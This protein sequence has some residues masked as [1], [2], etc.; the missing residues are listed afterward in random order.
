MN[1]AVTIAVLTHNRSRSLL[2]TVESLQTFT[3]YEP[4]KL[5]ILDSGS[6]TGHRNAIARLAQMPNVTLA[7]FPQPLTCCE[8]RRHIL[9][10]V[11]TPFVVYLDDDIT[12]TPRWL[13]RMMFWMQGQGDKCGAVAAQL[14]LDGLNP[15]SGARYIQNG[16]IQAH[17]FGYTGECD[18]C[19]GG[20]TL[21]RT[22]ALKKTEFR[23]EYSCGSEDMDMLLQLKR[24][25]GYSIQSCDVILHHVHEPQGKFDRQRWRDVDILDSSIGLWHRWGI[26]TK[27]IFQACR[28]VQHGVGIRSDQS[29]AVLQIMHAWIQEGNRRAS[30]Q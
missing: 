13:T 28:C 12:V 8:G 3:E 14:V 11:D 29:H 19:H 7:Y 18:I 17:P 5:V 10:Y 26:A 23:P 2:R 6:D 1:E 24:D 27:A 30:Q 9:R 25:H 20:A 4:C 21:Y 15:I 22:E 16:T